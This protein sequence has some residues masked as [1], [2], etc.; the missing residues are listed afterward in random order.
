[1]TIRFRSFKQIL[2]SLVATLLSGSILTGCGSS[3]TMYKATPI[4]WAGD[5]IQFQ[6]QSIADGSHPSNESVDVYCRNCNVIT[7]GWE[8]K[9]DQNGIGRVYIPESMTMLSTWLK[10]KASGID[11]T[12]VVKQIPPANAFTRYHLS[13]PLVGRVMAIQF[14]PL[15][16][17]ST[18]DSVVTSIESG[19]ELNI[20]KEDQYTYQV[21]HPRYNNPLFLVRTNAVRLF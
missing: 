7:L 2:F 5:T 13:Q 11:T 12:I 9:L 8:T 15:Y 4:P 19:D 16:S 21:H 3:A 14:A 17:D 20:Y 1:M 6:L 10:V 18:M